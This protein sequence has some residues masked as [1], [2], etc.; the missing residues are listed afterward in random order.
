MTRDRAK[1]V[2]SDSAL[3]AEERAELERAKTRISAKWRAM[4]RLI[5]SHR[6]QDGHLRRNRS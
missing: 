4:D 1:A 2:Y 3:T 6:Q 5:E